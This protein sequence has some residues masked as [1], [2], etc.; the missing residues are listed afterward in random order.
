M[1]PTKCPSKNLIWHTPMTQDIVP[2]TRR[3]REPPLAPVLTWTLPPPLKKINEMVKPSA[4]F[5]ECLHRKRG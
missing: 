1:N 5:R 3:R 4:K 2:S